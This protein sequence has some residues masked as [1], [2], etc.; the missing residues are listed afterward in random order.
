MIL[1]PAEWSPL[2]CSLLA[3]LVDEAGFPPGVLQRR[4]GD[5]RGDRRGAR[6]QSRRPPH[7]VH[8]LAR[9][10]APD[11]RRRGEEHRPV[12]GRARRQGAA[13]RLR[14]LRPRGRRAQGGRAVRRLRVRCASPARGCSSRSRCAE[15][16][17][18]LFHR[19]AD[20]HVLGDPRDDD[21]TVTPLIHPR[22]RRPRRRLRRARA[23]ERRRD[24][25]RR[26]RRAERAGSS[27]SRRSSCRA[28]TRARSCS[29]RSSGRC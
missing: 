5:R 17:L 7:L 23:G 1:K 3:D 18:E 10:R 6:L 11:R 14:G 8:R 9:D 19:F 26:T 2:S 25:P 12:H 16:F 13:A 20:E 28:R 27:T 4:A 29:A 24:R 22:A 15:P 21:T